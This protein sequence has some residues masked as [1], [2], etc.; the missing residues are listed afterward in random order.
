MRV[1]EREKREREPGGK[2]R[3]KEERERVRW[4]PV[5]LPRR[6]AG[7]T[8]WGCHVAGRG[9]GKE[10]EREGDMVRDVFPNSFVRFDFRFDLFIVRIENL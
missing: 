9:G 6:G 1:R 5:G 10:R 7:G 8:P 4:R 3:E 2:K